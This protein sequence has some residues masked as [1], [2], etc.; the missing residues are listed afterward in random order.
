MDGLRNILTAFKDCYFK[1]IPNC[2]SNGIINLLKSHVNRLLPLTVLINSMIFVNK[3]T[4]ISTIAR[5]VAR[6]RTIFPAA[7]APE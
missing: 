1:L 7:P 3:K 4:E 2:D 6:I 5:S